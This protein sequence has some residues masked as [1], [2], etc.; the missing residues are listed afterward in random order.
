MPLVSYVTDRPPDETGHQGWGHDGQEELG[1]ERG[2]ELP[3]GPRPPTGSRIWIPLDPSAHELRGQQPR[4]LPRAL[5]GSQ[6]ARGADVGVLKLRP[7]SGSR[8][9]VFSSAHHTSGPHLPWGWVWLSLPSTAGSLL[10]SF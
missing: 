5:P 7:P 1:V 10:Q 3:A 6:G 8:R 4:L 9:P 2:G